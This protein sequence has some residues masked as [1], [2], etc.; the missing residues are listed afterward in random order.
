MQSEIS[1]RNSLTSWRV[2]NTSTSLRQVLDLRCVLKTLETRVWSPDLHQCSPR[3]ATRPER[4]PNGGVGS[5]STDS[6]SSGSSTFVAP[7]ERALGSC[8]TEPDLFDATGRGSMFSLNR[9]PDDGDPSNGLSCPLS[10]YLGRCFEYLGGGFSHLTLEAQIRL[11]QV[12]I[13]LGSSL[14]L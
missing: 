2:S 1:P 9:P 6:G 12:N 7:V 10:E 4:R 13:M 5:S 14:H 8:L 3:S 11:Q